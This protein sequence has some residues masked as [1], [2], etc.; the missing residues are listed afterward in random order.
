MVST[1]AAVHAAS[2][3]SRSAWSAC[4]SSP[5]STACARRC[6]S[7]VRLVVTY[8]PYQWL[9]GFAAL[10]AVWREL[11][12]V[13]TWEK[14]AHTGA[15]RARSQPRPIA[16]RAPARM[17]ATW[18]SARRTSSAS[19]ARPRLRSPLAAGRGA[20]VAAAASWWL[21]LG[22]VAVGLVSHGLNMFQ[23]PALNRFD[24]EGIYPSQ[25]WAILREGHL[26]PYTYFYDHAPGGWIL[27]A[28]WMAVTGGPHAFGGAIDSGRV[29]ML[30]LHLGMV[31]CCTASRASWAAACAAAALAHAAVLGLA[32]GH[33]LSAARA[34]RQHHVVLGAA[35]PGPAA[36]RLGPPEPRGPQRRAASAWPC[37]A[38]RPRVF[39]LPAMLFIALAAALAAPGPLRRHRLAPADA[40][41]RELVPAVRRPQG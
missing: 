28:G 14:T 24:D 4:S 3:S 39:L 6:W 8:L 37:S 32:A 5:P 15:H 23:Y 40:R 20:G 16:L 21:V 26:S 9:L 13:N 7:C 10:R 33:L 41:G 30:L 38:R 17:A 34:A 19:A 18:L 29:L 11:R 12:G 1:A 36:G 2:S 25:A 27:L 22:L 35:Q 31:R